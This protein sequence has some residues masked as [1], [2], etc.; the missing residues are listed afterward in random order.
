MIE[1][2]SPA[3]HFLGI[4]GIGMS[5]LAHIALERG[6]KVCG[7]DR[8]SSQ[9]TRQLEE[10]GANIFIGDDAH[11]D[12]KMQVVYSS[13]IAESHPALQKAKQLNCSLYHRS[14]F[15]SMLMEGQQSILV[16][17]T[18]GKTS[19]TAMITWVLTHAGYDP[20]YA[21]GGIMINTGKN[22]G[23]G[24]GK[25]FVAEA[26][27]SDGSFLNYTG[28]Y[29]IIT[30][31][32]QEHMSYWK[33]EEQLHEGFK[34]FAS[35]NDNLFW[36]VDDS[37][38][39]SL[40]LK[41][42]SYG[43]SVKADWHL[44]NVYHDKMSVVFSISHCGVDYEDIRL[45]M[46]GRHQALNATAVW[47]LACELGIPEERV[48]RA[49]LTFGGVH[50]R[51]EKK[52]EAQGIVVYDD[53]AHHPTEVA[54]VLTALKEAIPG[55]YI[56]AIFQAHKYTRT[57]DCLH[58]FASAFQSADTVFITEIYAAGEQPVEGISGKTLSSVIP[59]S[60]FMCEDEILEDLRLT[61]KAGDV[62]V[63]IGAGTITVLGPKILNV[64]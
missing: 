31:V 20:S 6:S 28:H 37:S 61:A 18:H 63:T 14:G 49:F 38:L 45:P 42:H 7:I 34:S 64:L 54:A 32:E 29:G 44:Y 26:D 58:L 10:K 19:T 12:A 23:H 36:C 4:G 62:I 27:E 35:C 17:G 56:R 3:V 21:V 55:C 8:N 5:A 33:T 43:V 39:S 11:F 24:K 60:S 50:R 52:G 22:G 13:S 15:L 59:G 9:V 47:G 57:R 30:N 40:K 48:R 41:G 16:T 1:N 2:E 51:L 53:Y 25:Y 46:M